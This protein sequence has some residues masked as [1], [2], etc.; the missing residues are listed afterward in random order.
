MPQTPCRFSDF[1][2]DQA[3]GKFV[4]IVVAFGHL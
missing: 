1:Q 3:M 4:I 2:P